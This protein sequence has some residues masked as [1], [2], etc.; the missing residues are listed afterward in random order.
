MVGNSS[1]I[2]GFRLS[3]GK[4]NA[5]EENGKVESMTTRVFETAAVLMYGGANAAF[6]E[7]EN[8]HGTK[9][10][11]YFI[12]LSFSIF[13]VTGRETSV[14]FHPHKS[15]LFSGDRRKIE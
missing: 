2:S 13:S 5:R 15:F 7:R 12:P 11:K 9:T 4:Q 1:Y 6:G 14:L 8:F 10:Y 3:V